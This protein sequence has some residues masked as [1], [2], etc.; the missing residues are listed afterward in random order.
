VASAI[1]NEAIAGFILSLPGLLFVLLALTFT[2]ASF[3]AEQ[4]GLM[5]IASGASRGRPVGWATHWPRRLAALPRLLH[6]ALWQA[7]ILLAW[8]LPLAAIA[9]L[10]YLTLLGE[11]DINSTWTSSA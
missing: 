6:L 11:H 9:G 2:L 10:T 3:Y 4:A 5:H 1:T 8:L 7:G